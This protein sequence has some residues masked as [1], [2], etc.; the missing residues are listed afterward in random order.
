MTELTQRLLSAPF[1]T[2][3]HMAT[4]L[5]DVLLRWQERAAQRRRLGQMNERML[6]D[7]GLDRA[8]VWHEIDKPFWRV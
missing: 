2:I 7:I 1:P 6:R 3:S 8:D 4:R 5:V